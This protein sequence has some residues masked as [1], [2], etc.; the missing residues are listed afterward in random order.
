ML[1]KLWTFIYYASAGECVL[2]R[3][4]KPLLPFLAEV[5]KEAREDAGS[6]VTGVANTAGYDAT[7]TITRFEKAEAWP[8]DADNVVN[9]YAANSKP[10][11]FDLWDEAVKRA[12]AA[13]SGEPGGERRR[14]P[15]R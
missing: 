8:R 3:P 7:T 13:D 11:V 2:C 9:A 12:R 4:V 10:S 15:K 6:R 14:R 5:C 1:C